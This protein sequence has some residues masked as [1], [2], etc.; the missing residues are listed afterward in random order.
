[1]GEAVPRD[2]DS[3][4]RRCGMN[5]RKKAYQ[6]LAHILVERAQLTPTADGNPERLDERFHRHTTFDRRESTAEIEER[7]RV[8]A[9]S[10]E[11]RLELELDQEKKGLLPSYYSPDK[12]KEEDRKDREEMNDLK[13]VL[14]YR[15]N[16]ALARQ[17]DRGRKKKQ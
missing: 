3:S 1:M 2:S 17:V 12:R 5:P 15:E 6:R 7:I 9:A 16:L 11:T 10:I 13:A 4:Q 14:L 8:L